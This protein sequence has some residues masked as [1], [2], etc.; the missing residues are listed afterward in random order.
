VLVAQVNTFNLLF[1][2]LLATE[3]LLMTYQQLQVMAL[4]EIKASLDVVKKQLQNDI[5]KASQTLA[6]YDSVGGTQ[7]NNLA[8]EYQQLLREIGNKQWALNEL[9]TV[10]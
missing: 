10:K 5:S 7:F 8:Q 2:S 3:V 1:C 6:M 4:K 9:S